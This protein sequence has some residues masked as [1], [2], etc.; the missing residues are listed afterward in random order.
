MTTSKTAFLPMW[1]SYIKIK[2]VG[3][4]S[5]SLRYLKKYISKCA[6]LDVEDSKGTKTLAQCLAYRKRAY[7]LSGVFR[8]RMSDLITNM[9]NFADN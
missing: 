4:V 6:N 3:N 5:E 8:S 1:H 9:Q 2:G 7:C